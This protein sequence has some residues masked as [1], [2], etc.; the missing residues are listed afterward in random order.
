MF[1]IQLIIIDTSFVKSVI[2]RLCLYKD[3]LYLDE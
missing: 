3:R 2:F 1:V